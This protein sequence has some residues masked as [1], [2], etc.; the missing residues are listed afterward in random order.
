MN[1]TAIF[2]RDRARQAE[3]DAAAATLDNVRD[4]WT[5]AAKAWDEMASR[6]EKTAER[7]SVNEEAKL[8][9]EM[10]EDD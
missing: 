2:Y 1:S 8:A 7:R 4:R 6:A 5:R 10:A 3:T 9:S